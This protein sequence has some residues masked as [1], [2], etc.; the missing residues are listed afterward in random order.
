MARE[1][2][3]GRGGAVRQRFA[4]AR[5]DGL[6]GPKLQIASPRLRHCKCGAAGTGTFSS[7]SDPFCAHVAPETPYLEAKRAS[8]V[9]FDATVGLLKGVLPV[10]A[11]LNAETVRNHLQQVANRMEGEL[12]EE[13]FSF[14]EGTP[15]DH[16]ALT[17]AEG[18]IFVGID[19]G[20]VRARERDG[21]GRLTN[22]EVLVGKSM[23]EDRGD[24]YF[25]LVRSL[26]EKSGRRLHELLQD[27]GLQMNQEITFLT[28]GEDSIRSMVEFISPS[29]EHVLDR[30]HVTMRVTVLR[31]FARGLVNHHNDREEADEI[32][33]ALRRIKGCLWH[34][35]IRA[36]LSC[37][38]ALV[39]DLECIETRHPNIKAFRK[40]VCESQTCVANNAHTI[41]NYAERHRYG[42]R[43]SIA[44]V[45]STVNTV[46]GSAF[47]RSGRCDGPEPEHTSCF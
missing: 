35:N 2:A 45:E 27:Q 20:N 40:G 1:D 8:P 31:Q 37:I 44:F 19:G 16:A 3:P 11:T 4:V 38:D 39:M 15:R 6:D 47:P 24:R 30:F 23:A 28:D 42:E 26:D 33:R 17:P 41:P 25:G 18:S 5:E 32:D 13:R 14:I 12:G 29:A 34:G 10:G 36:V 46:V 21:E 43:V 22:F 7:L 9:S